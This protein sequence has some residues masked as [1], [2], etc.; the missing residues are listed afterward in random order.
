MEEDI[1]TVQRYYDENVEQE[2]ERLGRHPYEF[3][4]TVRMMERYLNPGDTILDIGG[5][6]GRYSLYFSRRG[7]DV[8]LYDLSAANIAFATKKAAEQGCAMKAIAGD[9]RLLTGVPEKH[10]DHVFIMGPLYHLLEEADRIR[11]IEAAMAKLKPGGTL[12]VSFLLLFA[13]FI[14]YMKFDPAGICTD[15]QREPYSSRVAAGETYGGDA[16]TKAYFINPAG[17][18]PFMARFPLEKITLFGQES[19]LAP[20]E[21]TLLQQPEAIQEE[22]KR[23]ALKLCENPDYLAY[24]EHAMYIGKNIVR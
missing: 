2:W 8:T 12:Y 6:P 9:A 15:P 20:H 19:I 13:G 11:V 3:E 21:L 5:G 1:K 16:F 24:S 7:Y 14:Y 10:Y 22:W 4:L 18:L 17:I 23:M